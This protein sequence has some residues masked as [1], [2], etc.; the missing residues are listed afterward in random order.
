LKPVL[1]TSDDLISEDELEEEKDHNANEEDNDFKYNNSGGKSVALVFKGPEI[2]K[3]IWDKA[4]RA[5]RLDV[6]REVLY[7][8]INILRARKDQ[9]MLNYSQ[10]WE[11]RG[12]RYFK[13]TL[14]SRS[15]LTLKFRYFKRFLKIINA[16]EYIFKLRKRVT[17]ARFYNGYIYISTNPYRFL[18]II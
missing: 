3:N 9:K 8:M 5:E 1:Y 6:I 16:G 12:S 15:A 17:F 2:L 14:L 7:N 13:N 4:S 18:S 10:E 11:E